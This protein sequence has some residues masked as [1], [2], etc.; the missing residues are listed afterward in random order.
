MVYRVALK[1]VL[2]V[3]VAQ[4]VVQEVF[5]ALYENM[6]R[7]KEVKNLSG[8]LYKATYFKCLD[9]LKKSKMHT[10][11]DGTIDI[12]YE[13]NEAATEAKRQLLHQA[14][15]TL[16]SKEKFLLILYGEGLSYKEIA[17]AA[18]INLNSVGKTISRL[19]KKLSKE[20]NREDYG[21]L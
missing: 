6:K 9:Y 11:I 1:M 5:V 17:L 16:K 10:S 8:W 12:E 21:L 3:D 4:D 2:S 13:D 20:L 18:D 19:V 15:N 7:K 14:L